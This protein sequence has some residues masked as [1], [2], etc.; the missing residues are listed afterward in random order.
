MTK[1][2]WGGYWDGSIVSHVLPGESVEGAARRRGK[3]ELGVDTDFSVA[4]SFYYQENYNASAENEYCYVLTGKTSE[5]I[6][7]NRQ[8]ISKTLYLDRHGLDKFLKEKQSQL[9]P[10]FI[11]AGEYLN[12]NNVLWPAS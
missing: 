2:L 11:K 1:S 8:E 7:A 4:G 6:I 9:T 10:W 3:E 5:A 12:L